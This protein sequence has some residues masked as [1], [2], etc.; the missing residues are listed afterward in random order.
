M[1]GAGGVCECGGDI[2]GAFGAGTRG[3]DAGATVRG[4]YQE[5][6]GVLGGWKGEEEEEEEERSINR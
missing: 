2:E 1:Y 6:R 3:R 5:G 4:G